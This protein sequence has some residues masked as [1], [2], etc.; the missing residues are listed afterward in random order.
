[1]TKTHKILELKDAPKDS[2]KLADLL[3]KAAY[4]Y[5]CACIPEQPHDYILKVAQESANDK[6]KS[7]IEN[8]KTYD[9]PVFESLVNEINTY[10]KL[11]SMNDTAH[12]TY[13]NTNKTRWSH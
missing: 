7:A 3:F 4:D 10:R 5:F 6:I 8:F 13:V 9:W 12:M 1:M 11:A 2:A